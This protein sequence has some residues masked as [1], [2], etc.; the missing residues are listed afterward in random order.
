MNR[1][2]Q[3]AFSKV[4]QRLAGQKMALL[5][6]RA[7]RLWECLQAEDGSLLLPSTVEALVTEFEA[8]KLVGLEWYCLDDSGSSEDGQ[9]SAKNK[10]D[11]YVIAMEGV[12]VVEVQCNICM[13]TRADV[14]LSGCDH[15]LCRG[16]LVA[17][18][19]QLVYRYN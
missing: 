6:M 4:Q 15:T 1:G 18:R 8:K 17:M 7:A 14:R 12:N 16:C 13:D 9:A 19:Q 10:K 11:L 2:G 5:P 3:A